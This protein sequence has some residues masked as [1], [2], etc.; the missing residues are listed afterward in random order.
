MRIELFPYE[1]AAL[2]TLEKKFELERE[3]I[4]GFADSLSVL[5]FLYERIGSDSGGEFRAG[6]VVIMGFISHIH[7]LLAGGL[8]ALEVGNSPVWA[9]CVRGL[10]ETFGACVR[11]SERP[12]TVI[13]HLENI[14]PGKLRAAAERG[15]PGI[16]GDLKR[17]DRIVHPGPGAIYAG[18]K[19]IEADSSRRVQ[20]RFALSQPE[21]AE[22]RS[23]VIM[24]ANLAGMLIQKLEELSSR[25]EI[26]SAGK[27]VMVDARLEREGT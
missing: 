7:H 11:I 23:G 27:L 5:R 25:N 17:L 15:Q 9:A 3:L 12:G 14:S 2:E 16:A 4:I 18:S 24:L 10:M 22:G 20:F 13:S 8:Q 19:V 21:H 26:L 1:R 6:R